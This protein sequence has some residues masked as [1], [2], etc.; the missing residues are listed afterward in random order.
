MSIQNNFPALKPTLLLDFANTKELDPRITFT[1]AS[2]ATYYGTQSAKAEENLLAQSQDLSTTW[3]T[4]N[5]VVTSNSTLAPD[6]TSTAD[7]LT[8]NAT[9]ASHIISQSPIL[10]AGTVYTFS[11]FLKAN[12]NNFAVV[13]LTNPTTVQ[14]G[15]SAVVDLSTGA[16]TQTATGTSATFTSSSITAVVGGWYRVVITGSSVAGFTRAEVGLVPASTGN[17]FSTTQRVSYVG[18]GTSVYVWGAQ[19]EPRSSVTA[20]TVTTTQPITNYIP[21]LETVASGVA[22]FDHNPVTDESLG[23]LIEESRTNL[24]TY[25]EQFDNG[26]WIKTQSNIVSNTVVA[27]NGALVG[28]LHLPN[29]T[30]AEH[31]IAQNFSFVSGTTYTLSIYLKAAGYTQCRIRFQSGAFGGTA[32]SID[33]DL[34]A[35]TT[36]SSSGSPISTITNVGNGW[37]RVTSTA[38]ATTTISA[39]ISV[40]PIIGGSTTGA[41]NGYSGIYIWG[42]QLEAG[43]F[44]TSYIPTVASQVTR[45]ADVALMT[46]T[47]F[48]SWYNHPQGT[49]FAQF[50]PVT[51]NYG[52]NRN[53][54]VVSDN[55]VN[56]FNGLRYSSTGTASSLSVSV[57]GVTQATVLSGT[58][59]AGTS[60]KLAGAYS[61]SDFASI[62]DGGALVTDNAGTVPV[63]TQ[64]E[65]GSL[66]STSTGTQTIKKIAYYPF[67]VTNAQLQGLTS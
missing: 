60:Y 37:Y 43:A 52:S 31:S 24:L 62:R 63:V 54:F 27:P 66:T 45:A 35:G 3:L 56:N 51:A 47:N 41:G 8:D 26:A 18:T 14:N 23:L 2:T 36:V 55:T 11:V 25:S 32:Q 44:A 33:V 19:L 5:T 28:D 13:T 21:L 6:N 59:V 46:G 38:T 4:T 58:M 12:T 67:R 48:S 42:A 64:A 61:A 34:V 15:I 7:T 30:A 9:S 65:I 40:F 22:R 50:T 10:T 53:I 1:R 20:Y 17:T 29:T 57:G 39:A 16:I 49:F